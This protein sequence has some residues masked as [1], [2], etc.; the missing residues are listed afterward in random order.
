VIK[1]KTH[2]VLSVAG[3]FVLGLVGAAIF[4]KESPT[5]AIISVL[6]GLVLGVLFI[7]PILG[8]SSR[9]KVIVNNDGLEVEWNVRQKDPIDTISSSNPTDSTE[10]EKAKELCQQ[11]RDILDGKAGE[12]NIDIAKAFE[13]FSKASEADSNYWE[14]RANMAGILVIKGKLEEAY[15]LAHQVREMAGNNTLAFA[16]GSLI[17]ATSI[18]TS[19]D[20]ESPIEKIRTKYQLIVNILEESLIKDEKDVVVRSAKI[21]S[22]ILGNYQKDDIL[23]DI[24]KGL[25]YPG[26]REEFVEVLNKDEALKKAFMS[27]YPELSVVIFPTA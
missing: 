17:M 8:Q 7:I 4:Y 10:S 13:C 1:N 24:K 25:S 27:E 19:I 2:S 14:P 9:G 20:P 18:E 26:F 21:K 15:N 6:G 12:K 3:M 5:I 22:K 23:N 16:N 11:G